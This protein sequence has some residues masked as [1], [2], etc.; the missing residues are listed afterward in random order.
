M[1]YR[2]TSDGHVVELDDGGNIVAHSTAG[3]VE[4]ARLP[5]YDVTELDPG[6]HP[7]AREVVE[8]PKGPTFAVTKPSNEPLGLGLDVVLLI[9][10]VGLLV[11]TI[12]GA[13]R[14][15][16]MDWLCRLNLRLVP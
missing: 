4:M 7:S 14:R 8:V 1:S 10:I 16:L 6:H 11:T 12:Y 13:G 3:T 2:L 5:R 9:A 15:V